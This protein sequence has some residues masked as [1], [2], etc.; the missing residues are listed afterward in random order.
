MAYKRKH[1]ER[2][3]E[4]IRKYM[5]DMRDR[6]IENHLC[7]RCGGQDERTL[8]GKTMCGPCARYHSAYM[9]AWHF[10]KWKE[11]RENAVG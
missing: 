4:D 11:E 10:R 8:E 9:K 5:A 2:H 6:R 3:K 1:Y 7:V